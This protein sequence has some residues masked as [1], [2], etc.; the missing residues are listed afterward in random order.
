MKVNLLVI[1]LWIGAVWLAAAPQAP[2]PGEKNPLAGDPAAIAAG[3]ELFARSCASCHSVESRAPSLA[4]GVF[5]RGGEDDQIAQSIRGGV[6]GTQMPA[7]PA[8]QTEAVWQLVA[9]IRS[10]S[11]AGTPAAGASGGGDAAAG[12]AVFNGKGGCV[13][14]HQVNARGGLVGPDLSA[15]GTRSQEALRHAILNP[16]SPAPTARGGIPPRPQVIVAKTRDGREVRGVRRSED[17]F[18][19]HVVDVSGQLHLL[20]K[21]A[22]ADLQYQDRSLMPGD[23]GTRLSAAELRDLLAYL[24]T[25]QGRDMSQDGRGSDPRR[26]DLRADS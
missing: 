13:A 24:Q 16:G 22:L 4:T 25:L 26:P 17:T 14:C 3:A 5:A 23:Y 20:D 15:A 2:R 12:E 19:V 7:F 18:S 1:S 6:P 8:L 10:L 9:Y 11:N 21:A